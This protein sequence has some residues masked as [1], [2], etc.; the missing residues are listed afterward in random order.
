MNISEQ[1]RS[2][3]L[4]FVLAAVVLVAGLPAAAQEGEMMEG[5][6]GHEMQ[7]GEMSADEAA[8]M[9]VW[10]KAMT[11]GPQHELLAKTAGDWNFT[12]KM[13][14]DPSGEP[15]ISEGTATR[16]LELGGRVVE[17]MV[18][19]SMMGMDFQGIAR[20][21]YDNLSGKWWSTWTDNMGTG[22]MMME[23]T[24]DEASQT[25]T[26]EGEG[27]DMMTGGTHAVKMTIHRVSEETE[28][29]EMWEAGPDGEMHRTMELTFTR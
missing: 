6:E 5:H 7:A 17:E 24:W 10:Q 12:I 20:T 2:L 14:M 22:I 28:V 1:S 3:F 4:V 13:W 18:H 16:T 15:E 29:S 23:G 21:G 19:G 26:Y 9:E 25:W 11:P 27:P 8:M